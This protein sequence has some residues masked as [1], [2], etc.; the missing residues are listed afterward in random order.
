MHV[1]SCPPPAVAVET[2]RPKYLPVEIQTHQRG[3]WAGWAKFVL[4]IEGALRPERA[5][6]VDERLP[7]GAVHAESSGDAEEKGVVLDHGVG[8]REGD[9]RVL[10]R[11]V[12][13]AGDFLRKR[14]LDPGDLSQSPVRKGT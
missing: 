13:L 7:L 11:G 12:H 1:V 10:W 6:L 14:F 9:R 8:G 4:I 5:E 2:K 3:Y